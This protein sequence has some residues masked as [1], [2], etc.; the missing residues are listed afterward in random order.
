MV[1][2]YLSSVDEFDVKATIQ[3]AVKKVSGADGRRKEQLKIQIALNLYKA[4]NGVYPKTLEQLAPSFVQDIP[5][6]PATGKKFSYTL[7]NNTAYVGAEGDTIIAQQQLGIGDDSKEILATAATTQEML[8]FVYNP[9]SKRDP[10]KPFEYAPQQ[11]DDTAKTPLERYDYN[12][13]RVSAVLDGLEQP[14]AM[15][16]DSTGKGYPATIGTKIGPRGGQIIN[17]Q[18]DKIVILETFEDAAGSIKTKEIEIKLRGTADE[19]KSGKV[20]QNAK[21]KKQKN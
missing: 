18:K 14:K 3:N 4:K 19:K 16:E 13:I 20:I 12:E 11:Q 10:F 21:A 1:Y 15:L 5:N 8:A 2:L 9:S 7:E 6:D 17:I